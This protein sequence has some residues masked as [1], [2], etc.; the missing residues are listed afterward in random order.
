[1]VT[2]LRPSSTG[3]HGVFHKSRVFDPTCLVE[4]GAKPRA[5]RLVQ[6]KADGLVRVIRPAGHAKARPYMLNRDICSLSDFFSK[7]L[8]G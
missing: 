4:A 6:V 1:M 8:M 5:M 3:L 2:K 7:S